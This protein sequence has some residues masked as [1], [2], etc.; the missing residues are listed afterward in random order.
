MESRHKGDRS[1]RPLIR[2]FSRRATACGLRARL[3]SNVTPQD[4]PHDVLLFDLDGTL[5]DPLN[6]IERSIKYALAEHD[7]PP[8]APG[9]AAAFIGPQIDQSFTLITGIGSG[10]RL[11]GLVAKYRERCADVGY[12]EN[13]L[14]PGVPEALTALRAADAVMGICTSKR[15]D[16]AEKILDLFDLRKYFRFVDGGEVGV[17]KWQQIEALLSVGG[18]TAASVM[19]GD[20]AV[21]LVAA[22]RNSLTSGGVLWGYGS[23]AELSSEHP[24]YLFN[25]PEEW[26][27]LVG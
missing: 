7:F 25:S 2:R 6:G 15:V 9:G 22:H 13:V 21:D 19:I 18:V 5:S 17:H 20:R 27:T 8:L 24:H 4:M 1:L 11:N 16:F 23:Y 14:Y 3:S 26:S 12:A 10:E